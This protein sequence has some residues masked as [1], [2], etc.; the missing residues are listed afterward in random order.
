MQMHNEQ[1]TLG[2]SVAFV[3]VG[4][5]SGQR[6]ALRV[7]PAPASHGI[8]LIHKHAGAD[9]SSLPATLSHVVDTRLS[10][11][12]GRPD[13][14]RFVTVEH[15]L[16]ALH[17]CG[18]DNAL[19]EVSGSEIPI[20]DGSARPFVQSFAAAKLV[21]QPA[22]RWVLVVT[23]PLGVRE[24]ER[25][26]AVTP[27]AAR[28]FTVEID[29]ANAAI[30]RQRFS[31]C[32]DG[33]GFSDVV[34]PARTFGFEED[35]ERLY[36]QGLARGG[37]PRNAIVIGGDRVINPEGLRFKD[38]FVRHKLLDLIGDVALA[39][40][41]VMGHFYGYRPGHDLNTRL[42]RRLVSKPDAWTLVRADRLDT[43]LRHDP[44]ACLLTDP[45]SS[46]HTIVRRVFDGAMVE[47]DGETQI[48][49]ASDRA[50]T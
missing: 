12:L 23:R 30:G 4:L 31:A 27:A 43:E 3:G 48:A 35:L 41:P 32:L 44:L 2:E 18:V 10:T 39:G 28:R 25:F 5:H 15:L 24:G 21:A 19:V 42:L 7:S 47:L 50:S 22:A 8:R 40:V 13:A 29:F 9:A 36:G 14:A 45:E 16:A 20:M 26:V 17:G 11:T 46:H 6:S 49:T 37:S 33:R 38:E 1:R 34:A